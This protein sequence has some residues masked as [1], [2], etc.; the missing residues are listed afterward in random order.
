MRARGLWV[1][2]AVAGTA[3]AGLL[4][5]CGLD[6]GGTYAGGVD[7][8]IDQTSR[9]APLADNYVAPDVVDGNIGIPDSGDAGFEAGC[10]ES[11]CNGTC[12]QGTCTPGA[13]TCSTCNGLP[14][15][16]TEANGPAGYCVSDCTVDCPGTSFVYNGKCTASCEAFGTFECGNTCVSDCSQ[17]GDAG[18]YGCTACSDGGPLLTAQCQPNPTDCPDQGF[19]ANA[20]CQC[21]SGDAG[22]CFGAS[23]VCVGVGPP[24]PPGTNAC[25]T[26]GQNGSDPGGGPDTNNKP[27]KNG[28]TCKTGL[29]SVCQ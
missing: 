2:V 17:C 8:S 12:C 27:C 6:S 3:G 20:L 14:F 5:A 19:Q 21:P 23:Q 25:L 7:A 11:S 26:C 28:L 18:Q 4:F 1:A 22:E 9:D 29:Q 15:F 16:C 24:F 13:Y 10:K